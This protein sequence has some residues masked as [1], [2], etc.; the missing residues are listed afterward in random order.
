MIAVVL[1]AGVGVYVYQWSR[2]GMQ[3]TITAAE[4]AR[5]AEEYVRQAAA[6]LPAHARLVDTGSEEIST[7]PCDLPSD[8]GAQGRVQVSVGYQIHDLDPAKFNEY[9]DALHGFWTRN[10]YKV[11]HDSRP[12]D[13]YLWVQQ[14]PDEFRFSLEG[15]D[16]GELYLGGVSPCLWPNGTPPS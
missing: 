7:S 12:K 8:H 6:H 15:N 2:R 10:G 11:L 14:E 9:F 13:W 16:L 1:V 5:R 4:G 3:P